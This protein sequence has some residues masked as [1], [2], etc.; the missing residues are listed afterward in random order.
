MKRTI[1]FAKG[2]AAG[3]L[4]TL[5]GGAAA[6]YVLHRMGVVYFND[7]PI[8]SPKAIHGWRQVAVSH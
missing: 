8:S 3:A 7:S 4:G 6:L 1:V 5:I 2:L